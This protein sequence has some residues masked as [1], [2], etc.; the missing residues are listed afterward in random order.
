VVLRDP[1]QC[2]KWEAAITMARGLSAALEYLTSLNYFSD[3]LSPS[4]AQVD[5]NWQ[6]KLCACVDYLDEPAR[7]YIPPE[8]MNG[9]R[10][11]EKS[12]VY[13]FGI[14]FW[15]ILTRS[16]RCCVAVLCCCVVLHVCCMLVCR[17]RC[18]YAS[19]V[20]VHTGV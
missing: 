18:V 19:V 3:S 7:C 9:A 15:E 1:Q 11:T 5:D 12:T 16:S 8:V 17:C 13:T 10:V 14:I 6:V 2:Y 20:C 4:M